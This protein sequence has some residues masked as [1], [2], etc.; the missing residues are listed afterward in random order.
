MLF[1][2][3]WNGKNR[4]CGGTLSSAGS[5]CEPCHPSTLCPSRHPS[6]CASSLQPVAVSFPHS[7]LLLPCSLVSSSASKGTPPNPRATQP[8]RAQCSE[9]QKGGWI[10]P[11][12]LS[13][14]LWSYILGKEALSWILPIPATSRDAPEC[15]PGS[16]APV[17]QPPAQLLQLRLCCSPRVTLIHSCTAELRRISIP[18]YQY[19]LVL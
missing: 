6:P 17:S 4:S 3:S 16:E 7:W 2:Y 9:A 18:R 19:L 5:L 12:S 11:R 13:V 8:P 15:E 14:A 1:Q 10:Y